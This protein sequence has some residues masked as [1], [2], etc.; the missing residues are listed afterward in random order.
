MAVSAA[1]RCTFGAFGNT[2]SARDMLSPRSRLPWFLPVA[3]TR[4]ILAVVLSPRTVQPCIDGC[5]TRID[6]KRRIVLQET[7]YLVWVPVI[8]ETS[9]DECTKLVVLLDLL[10]LVGSIP[11]PRIGFLFCSRSN[12]SPAFSGKECAYLCRT[13]YA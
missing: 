6:T 7:S 10:A 3:R 11:T 13:H 1:V 12:V 4:E 5:F 9:D 8:F 2:N